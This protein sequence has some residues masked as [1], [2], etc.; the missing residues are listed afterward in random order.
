[1]VCWVDQRWR[2]SA[3]IAAALQIQGYII[4]NNESYMAEPSVVLGRIDI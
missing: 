2:A 4:L 1:M 3:P